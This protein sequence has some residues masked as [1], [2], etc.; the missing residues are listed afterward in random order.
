MQQLQTAASRAETPLVGR[1][2]HL[3]MLAEALSE[4]TEATAPALVTILAAPGVGKSRL[5]AELRDASE[6][7]ATL[8]G[9]TPSY[10]DGIT[11]APLVE[12]L[13]EA[14]GLP[15]GEADDVAEQLRGTLG[16]WR[17]TCSDRHPIR[18]STM[19]ALRRRATLCTWS[20]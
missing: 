7:F 19:C 16:G 2:R 17:D 13:S 14:A 1:D 11:F 10:G 6:T 8:V 3:A 18:S 9:Q 5:A 20:S 4:A 15:G 12:L